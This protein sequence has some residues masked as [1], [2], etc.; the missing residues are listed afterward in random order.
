MVKDNRSRLEL[1]RENDELRSRLADAE[2]ALLV[3]K[4]VESSLR[5]A[6]LRLELALNASETGAWDFNA[7]T[8]AG[9]HSPEHAAIFGFHKNGPWSMKQFLAHVLPEDRAEI[10][11]IFQEAIATERDLTFE[12]RIRRVDGEVRWIWGA[13]WYRKNINSPG[14]VSGVT[15]DITER[16]K[17]E[18]DLVQSHLELERRVKERTAELETANRELNSFCYS[19]THELGAPLR[20]ISCFSSIL[21]EEFAE[22]MAAEGKELLERIGSAAV[23]MGTLVEDLLKLSRVTRSQVNRKKLD[24]SRLAREIMEE[25]RETTP[26]REL[27]VVIAKGVSVRWDPALAEVMLRNLLEN[28]WKYTSGRPLSRIEFGALRQG[29]EKVY[30]V[31]DNGIGF[32]MSYADRIFRPFERLHRTGEYAG[33]GVGLATVQRIVSLHGGRIWAE[34]EAEKGAT[35]YFT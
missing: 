24:L 12:C 15:R 2:N 22:G 25:L 3:E 30:Y 33:N 35:F 26:N 10:V 5:E 1:L 18:M 28:A 11:V 27:E 6:N 20:G 32:D 34:S 17:A 8:G 4:G 16:K 14:R 23:R 19:V 31:R 7:E 9:Y 21:L 29:G 13:G